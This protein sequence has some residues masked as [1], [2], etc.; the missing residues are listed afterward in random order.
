MPKV[1]KGDRSQE[2]GDRRQN[3][4]VGGLIST[5]HF[6]SISNPEMERVAWLSFAF[7]A[8][9]FSP[10]GKLE[11]QRA[12]TQAEAC[13]YRVRKRAMEI[14]RTLAAAGGG[15]LQTVNRFCFD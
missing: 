14:R 8:A 11:I 4:N 12:L 2:T 9:G 7:V 10:R 15:R 5:Q 13:A 6:L 3:E 1:E